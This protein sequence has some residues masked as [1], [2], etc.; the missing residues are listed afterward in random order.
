MLEIPESFNL[1]KQLDQ[2]VKNRVIKNVK[3]A[4]SPHKFAFYFNDDPD[5]YDSLLSGKKLEKIEPEI[6]NAISGNFDH[7]E[8]N[9]DL[10]LKQIIKILT[11]NP[12]ET[13]VYSYIMK[14]HNGLTD[15][16]NNTVNYL[17]IDKFGV[18]YE[19]RSNE[20]IIESS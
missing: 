20:K 17:N 14:K 12:Y 9:P 6:R 3:A 2:T 4:Q 7:D 18:R 13:R 5:N 15:E 19:C 11:L 10:E 16:L 8:N 1:A